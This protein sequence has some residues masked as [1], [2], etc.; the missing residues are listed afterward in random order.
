MRS[1]PIAFLLAVL[2]VLVPLSR[3]QGAEAPRNPG[4]KQALF[5]FIQIADPQ[6]GFLEENRGFARD[7]ARLS[8]A[9]DHVNRLRPRFVVVTGDLVNRVGDAAQAAECSKVLRKISPSISVHFTAGNHDVGDFP[10]PE[11]IA[12]FRKTFGPDHEA[13]EVEGWRFISL[14]SGVILRPRSCQEE[15]DRQKEWLLG[16]LRRPSPEPRR[17]IV[18]QHHPWFIRSP[19]EPD[20]TMGMSRA[21]RQEFLGVLKE[22]GVRAVFAG[23]THRGAGGKDGTLEMVTSSAVGRP[24]GKDPPGIRIVWVFDDRIE[25]RYYGLDEVPTKVSLMGPSAARRL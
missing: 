10:T 4:K 7:S 14:D 8:R 16:E 5:T 18:F 21:L 19:D 9:V 17:I 2:S 6:L 12:W 25:H 20:E 15:R 3:V 23:H 11:S 13:F 1:L 22:S 24:L